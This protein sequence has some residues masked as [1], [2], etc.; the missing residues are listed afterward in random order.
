LHVINNSLAEMV[1]RVLCILELNYAIHLDLD[2]ISISLLPTYFILLTSTQRYQDRER[3][4]Q[5]SRET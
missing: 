2:F 5:L 4:L 1:K 3:S